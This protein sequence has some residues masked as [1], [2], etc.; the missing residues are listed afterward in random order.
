[1][2]TL[3]S[4]ESVKN[5]GWIYGEFK[6]L[7]KRCVLSFEWKRVGLTDGNSGDDGIGEPG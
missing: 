3:G 6:D 4:P 7:W 5:G 2:G 1:M